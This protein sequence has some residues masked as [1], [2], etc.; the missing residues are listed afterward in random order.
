VT[1]PRIV[2]ERTRE[3]M[4]HV[5]RDIQTGSF[6]REFLLENQVG[7]PRLQAQRRAT[8]ETLVSQVGRRLRKMMPF[9]AKDNA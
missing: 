4:K 8:G 6:A 7:Q 9:I 1:G 5:L 3:E 2:T